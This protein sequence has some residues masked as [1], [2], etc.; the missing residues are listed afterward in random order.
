MPTI[1]EARDSR[2][3][4]E[5]GEYGKNVDWSKVGTQGN[6]G[7]S[8]HMALK[9]IDGKDL[10][11]GGVEGHKIVKIHKAKT[12]RVNNKEVKILPGEV[13]ELKKPVM[14]PESTRIYVKLAYEAIADGTVFSQTDLIKTLKLVDETKGVITYGILTRNDEGYAQLH[15]IESE[16]TIKKNSTKTV[17]ITSGDKNTTIEISHNETHHSNREK[18]LT[19]LQMEGVQVKFENSEGNDVAL[20]FEAIDDGSELKMKVLGE[21]ILEVTPIG[22]SDKWPE[23][24]NKNTKEDCLPA[25]LAARW[26]ISPTRIIFSNQTE[27]TIRPLTVVV[28]FYTCSKMFQISPEMTVS[29][30]TKKA[31]KGFNA[32]KPDG[33][34]FSLLNDTGQVY[35][36]TERAEDFLQEGVVYCLGFASKFSVIWDDIVK[37]NSYVVEESVGFASENLFDETSQQETE[38]EISCSDIVFCKDGRLVEGSV[39]LLLKGKAL[40]S[41]LLRLFK[42]ESWEA[43]TFEPPFAPS[44]VSSAASLPPMITFSTNPLVNIVSYIP[45]KTVSY[46]HYLTQPSPYSSLVVSLQLRLPSYRRILVGS[47][48][49]EV[50]NDEVLK[51]LP[52]SAVL[53]IY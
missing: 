47:T 11:T 28:A 7:G 48:G 49:V 1:V 31:V 50:K 8:K 21:P 46:T 44:R 23:H 26:G 39:P 36:P 22:S 37:R 45:S 34:E 51:G 33:L 16:K 9:G 30:L 53:A 2:V 40:E 17:K 35:I 18:I 29:D 5:N 14:L 52:S 4:Y 6:S 38:H 42:L 27:V 3:V 12:V 25:L 43:G 32:E 15:D 13:K 20:T 10:G 24:F 19:D 41:Y